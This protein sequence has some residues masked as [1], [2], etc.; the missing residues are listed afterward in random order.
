MQE[1]KIR[2]GVSAVVLAAGMSRRMGTLKQLLP[3]DGKM[4]LDVVLAAVRASHVDEVIVVLGNS[5]DIIQQHVRLDKCKIVINDCYGEGISSSLR[6][7]VAGVS[8]HADGALIVLADQ[9]L[10][11]PETIDQLIEEYRRRKPQILIPVYN[12]VR[13][14]PVLLDRSVFAELA[15]LTGDIGCR[16]IFGKHTE[17]LL[18]VP[19]DDCGVLFDLD[20]KADLEEAFTHAPRPGKTPPSFTE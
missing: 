10:I 3:I 18:K 16:A 19:V 12:G 2:S 17:G 11:R 8:P 7:G 9:P 20:T 14:N 4:L 15:G 1:G 6:A 13:G 5:A